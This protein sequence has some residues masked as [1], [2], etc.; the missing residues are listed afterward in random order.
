MIHAD[1]LRINKNQTVENIHV[2]FLSSSLA[3]NSIIKCKRKMFHNLASCSTPRHKKTWEDVDIDQALQIFVS[4]YFSVRWRHIIGKKRRTTNNWQACS[5]HGIIRLSLCICLG[6]IWWIFKERFSNGWKQKMD[7]SYLRNN[8]IWHMPLCSSIIDIA[9]EV[10][11]R[12]CMLF[13]WTISRYT[14]IMLRL[15]RRSNSGARK[16]V[17]FYQAPLD[18]WILYTHWDNLI[19]AAG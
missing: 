2:A 4:H 11:A 14:P 1:F 5:V 15:S 19:I 16:C 13:A 8:F 7:F 9:V 10:A 12:V 17:A 6:W 3:H 18:Q